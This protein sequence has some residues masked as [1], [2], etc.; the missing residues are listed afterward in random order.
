ML[1]QISEYKIHT[2][3]LQEHGLGSMADQIKAMRRAASER[4]KEVLAIQAIVEAVSEIISVRLGEDLDRLV[5]ALQA[6]V[7]LYNAYAAPAEEDGKSAESRRWWR[8]PP[9]YLGLPKLPALKIG[10]LKATAASLRYYRER[11]AMALGDDWWREAVHTLSFQAQEE[12]SLASA[13][14]KEWEAARKDITD[15]E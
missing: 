6:S 2:E 1:T 15:G 13:M 14:V 4:I 9:Y 7:A 10:K 12:D 11:L 5:E 3:V 8:D